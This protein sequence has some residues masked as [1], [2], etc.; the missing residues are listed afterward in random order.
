MSE[1]VVRAYN[2]LF[3][4]ALLVSIPERD[5]N[6]TETVR[7]LLIDVGNLLANPD[8][9]FTDVVKDIAERAGGVVDLYVMTHEHMD[10][11][12][13]LLAAANAGVALSA[14]YAWLTG[15]ADPD[16]YTNHPKAKEKK[17][18]LAQ[19]LT[20]LAI[21][22]RATPD[23]WLEMMIA[24]NSLLLPDGALGLLTTGDYVDH[25]R[26]LAPADNTTYVDRTT[27]LDGRHPFTEATLR[28]LAP[29]EDTSTYY[30]RFQQPKLTAASGDGPAADA[31]A[32]VGGDGGP[33]VGIDAGA[34][35]DLV[36]ARDNVNA[37]SVLAIDAAANNTSV[38]IE[39]TW[40]G[41]KLLFCGDAEKRS[42]QTM[43]AKQQLKP[44]HFVKIAHH[45]SSTGTVADIFDTVM[46]HESPD[47]KPRQAIVSTRHHMDWP[48]VPD[49][50]TLALYSGRC[51]LLDTSTVEPG[52]AVEARFSGDDA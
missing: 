27:D 18:S 38:V 9:V 2:V 34:F 49:D 13:G 8:D 35:Y 41:W 21:Q 14:R 23:P 26:T 12:Q 17:N 20:S 10:H 28:I 50:D 32:P 52:Q 40:R 44:V 31:P 29:E 46:P 1:L 3:G 42:W 22:Q 48:S 47:G 5:E 11:V 37:A 30:G 25:L 39:I 15:S 36:N 45:G 6:G 51:T 33:P 24:N 4:D 19:A 43:L 7:T 16:Y